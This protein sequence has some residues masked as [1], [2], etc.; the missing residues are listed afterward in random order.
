MHCTLHCEH[1]SASKCIHLLMCN[2]YTIHQ[3]KHAQYLKCCKPVATQM[4][5]PLSLTVVIQWLQPKVMSLKSFISKQISL[6]KWLSCSSESWTPKNVHM[7]SSVRNTC[8]CTNLLP[9]SDGIS[10]LVIRQIS[11]HMTRAS[12][13]E[14]TQVRGVIVCSTNNSPHCPEMPRTT[15]STETWVPLHLD[16][17]CPTG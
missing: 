10:P 2:G 12:Q 5:K 11:A 1:I 9:A 17:G 13:S 16:L 15:G 7:F 3:N 4:P 8:S 14:A 6:N